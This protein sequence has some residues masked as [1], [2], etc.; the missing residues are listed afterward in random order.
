MHPADLLFLARCN[1][2]HSRV[3]AE[4]DV[5]MLTG[6]AAC[7]CEMTPFD[8]AVGRGSSFRVTPPPCPALPATLA[9]LMVPKA[10]RSAHDA[11]SPGSYLNDSFN[12][13]RYDST[14]PSSVMFTSCSTTSATRRSRKVSAARSMA[15]LAAFSQESVLVPTSSM[16]L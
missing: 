14:F 9:A 3:G 13:T 2:R 11:Q 5:L 4:T 8:L 10:T 15:A 16:T 6:S 7:R 12:L 1:P